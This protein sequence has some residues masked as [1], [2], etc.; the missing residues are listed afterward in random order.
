MCSR[1]A[2]PQE[3]ALGELDHYRKLRGPKS[4]I[5]SWRSLN[6]YEMFG[7]R[8]PTST[9]TSPQYYQAVQFHSSLLGSMRAAAADSLRP[10]GM[11]ARES[12]SFDLHKPEARLV[13]F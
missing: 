7:G 5:N 9:D 4:Y 2:M 1:H 6:K 12:W 13:G 11:D 8:G 10:Q 3:L